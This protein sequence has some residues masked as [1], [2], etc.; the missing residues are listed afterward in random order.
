MLSQ[1]LSYLVDDLKEKF[2]EVDACTSYHALVPD[3]VLSKRTA[4]YVNLPAIKRAEILSDGNK[5]ITAQI[6]V[7]IRIITTSY[8]A[9]NIRGAD[10]A[11]D[12][13][14]YISTKRWAVPYAFSAQN[15]QA[16]D[17]YGFN[18]DNIQIILGDNSHWTP[19]I[20]AQV[21]RLY[22]VS[23]GE[24]DVSVWMVSWEQPLQFNQVE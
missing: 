21:Q 18:K 19:S 14:G 4:L 24:G 15:V 13:L 1:F 2:K 7:Y 12:L 8:E 6:I 11:A 23:H 10:I 16:D 9:K 22:D 17:C 20:L 3:D 5:K